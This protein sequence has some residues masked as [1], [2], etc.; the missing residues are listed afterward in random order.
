MDME[1]KKRI[2]LSTI[3]LAIILLILYSERSFSG[4]G[5]IAEYKISHILVKTEGEAEEI[6]IALNK[7]EDFAKL[8]KAKSNGPSAVAKN[9]GNGAV[10]LA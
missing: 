9:H 8:A 1:M 2:S 5:L 4:V 10:R 3:T 6:I 7:G